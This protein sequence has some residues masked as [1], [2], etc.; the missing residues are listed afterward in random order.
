MQRNTQV[1]VGKHNNMQHASPHHEVATDV[2]QMPIRPIIID[3]NIYAT[4]IVKIV[5]TKTSAMN[6]YA[7]L[8]GYVSISGGIN[9]LVPLTLVITGRIRLSVST[10]ISIYQLSEETHVITLPYV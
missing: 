9:S 8:C 6:P 7:I 3:W 5:V 4:K 1:P 10:E 2:K